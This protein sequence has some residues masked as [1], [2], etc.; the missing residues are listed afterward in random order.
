MCV[1]YLRAYDIKGTRLVGQYVFYPFKRLTNHT[2][3]H[4]KWYTIYRKFWNVYTS[5]S[6]K[7]HTN[8]GC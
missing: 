4:V 2:F 6:A 5:I 3:T 8:G 7:H 1:C